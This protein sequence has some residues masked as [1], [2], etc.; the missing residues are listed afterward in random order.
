MN[1]SNSRTTNGSLIKGKRCTHLRSP[2][3]EFLHCTNKAKCAIFKL[4]DFAHITLTNKI[5]QQ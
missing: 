5:K 1:K 3:L 2:T 4:I